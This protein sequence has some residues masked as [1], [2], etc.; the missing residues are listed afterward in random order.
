VPPRR[1]STLIIPQRSS[2]LRNVLWDLRVHHIVLLLLLLLLLCLLLQLQR[3]KLQAAKVHCMLMPLQV[4]CML[5][6]SLR[7]LHA[8]LL[9]FLQPGAIRH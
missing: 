5:R 2:P 6:L 1:I 3:C 9:R 4:V 8:L 7:L